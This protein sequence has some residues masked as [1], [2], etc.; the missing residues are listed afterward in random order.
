MEIILNCCTA[1]MPLVNKYDFLSVAEIAVKS[2]AKTLQ[3]FANAE[4]LICQ[5]Q[6][7]NLF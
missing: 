4:S 3:H 5:C 2:S 1:S 6:S 7:S